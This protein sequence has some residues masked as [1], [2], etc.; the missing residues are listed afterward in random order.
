MSSRP[1]PQPV[2]ALALRVEI[3][4]QHLAIHLRKAGGQVD[5]RRGL[6]HAALAVGDCERAFQLP[7]P[8]TFAPSTHL[9]TAT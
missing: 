9:K 4:Q 5:G 1:T 2:V 6:A 7:T 3:D 8:C